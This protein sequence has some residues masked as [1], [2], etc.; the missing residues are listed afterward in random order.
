MINELELFNDDRILKSTNPKNLKMKSANRLKSKN[1]SFRN[2]KKY[3]GL[4]HKIKNPRKKNIK[5]TFIS[6]AR[7]ADFGEIFHR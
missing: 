7:N 6:F 5:A 3:S 4:L 2:H 1:S